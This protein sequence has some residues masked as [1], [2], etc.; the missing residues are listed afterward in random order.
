MSL[1]G[2]KRRDQLLFLVFDG[3]V[4]RFAGTVGLGRAVAFLK[5]ANFR[6]SENEK[7][8]KGILDITEMSLPQPDSLLLFVW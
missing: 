8:E 7:K 3:R 1:L 2:I 5:R 6:H 4:H